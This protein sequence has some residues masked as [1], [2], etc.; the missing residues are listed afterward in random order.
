MNRRRSEVNMQRWMRKRT[1]QHLKNALSLSFFSITSF[2]GVLFCCRCANVMW[3]YSLFFS[4][5]STG[6]TPSFGQVRERSTDMRFVDS[7]NTHVVFF[8]FVLSIWA[9]KVGLTKK[10]Q[11][12]HEGK[13]KKEYANCLATQKY[14]AVFACVL[15]MVFCFRYWRA[16]STFIAD[17]TIVVDFFFVRQLLCEGYIPFFVSFALVHYT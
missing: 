16:V 3:T 13:K 9:H 12:R 7:L 14:K 10:R 15:F 5:M 4:W 6:S 8:C 1:A 2:N 17:M 11:K